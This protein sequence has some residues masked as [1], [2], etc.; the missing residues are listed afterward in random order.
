[1]PADGLRASK[2]NWR[3]STV[4]HLPYFSGHHS[5]HPFSGWPRSLARSTSF[6]SDF[7]SPS[8]YILG[9]L[10]MWGGPI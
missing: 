4:W 2:G 8:E 5:V 3:A 7:R 10:L 6:L 9:E 1:M